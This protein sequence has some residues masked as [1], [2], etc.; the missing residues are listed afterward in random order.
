MFLFLG[1]ALL[2]GT[3]RLGVH[4]VEEEADVKKTVQVLHLLRTEGVLFVLPQQFF[5]PSP[6]LVSKSQAEKRLRRLSGEVGVLGLNDTFPEGRL[7]LGASR[8]RVQRRGRS[9]LLLAIELGHDR[10]PRTSFATTP[11]YQISVRL[12]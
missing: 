10:W 5:N 4:Q 12:R 3:S 1:A 2:E 11:G 7:T 6:I 9:I 8:G